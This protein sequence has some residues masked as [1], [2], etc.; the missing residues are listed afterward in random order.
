M[1]YSGAHH[2]Y[3][4]SMDLPDLEHEPGSELCRVFRV[5]RCVLCAAGVCW[6]RVALRTSTGDTVVVHGLPPRC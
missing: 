1:Q 5:D 3:P 4:T 2:C 6:Q